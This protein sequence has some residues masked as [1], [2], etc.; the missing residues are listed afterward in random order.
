MP[1]HAQKIS[2]MR[3][4]LPI[5]RAKSAALRLLAPLIAQLVNRLAPGRICWQ[6]LGNR[7]NS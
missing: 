4:L 1:T 3:V 2:A 7:I 5:K 6:L